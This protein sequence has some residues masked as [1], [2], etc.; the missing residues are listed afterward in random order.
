MFYLYYLC[1]VSSYI[2]RSKTFG[3]KFNVGQ[4]LIYTW[5]ES[6]REN[7][8]LSNKNFTFFLFFFFLVSEQCCQELILTNFSTKSISI[9]FSF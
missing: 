5:A 6:T 7:D 9:S 1:S 8:K 3:F 2:I 4:L